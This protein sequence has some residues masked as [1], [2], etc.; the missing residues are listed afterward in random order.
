MERRRGIR[1][2]EVVQ[3]L[4]RLRLRLRMEESMVGGRRLR[5]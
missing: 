2:L 3:R 1:D 5:Y 4:M